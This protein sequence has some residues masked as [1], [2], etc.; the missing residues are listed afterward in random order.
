MK[1][2]ESIQPHIVPRRALAAAMSAYERLLMGFGMDGYLADYNMEEII[3]AVL[4]SDPR[5]MAAAEGMAAEECLMTDAIGG[6]H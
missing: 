1:A 5:F 3:E 6:P 2:G 4:R